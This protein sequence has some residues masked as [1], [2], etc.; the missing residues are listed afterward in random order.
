[1]AYLDPESQLSRRC[2]ETV[3][4]WQVATDLAFDIKRLEDCVSEVSDDF[5]IKLREARFH[6]ISSVQALDMALWE[7][8]RQER[9]EEYGQKER[10]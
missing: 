4:L 8:I 10:S 5:M 2:S 3:S 6:V 1:M 9:R 7:G